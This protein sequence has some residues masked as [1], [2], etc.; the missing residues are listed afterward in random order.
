MT[1]TILK[2]NGKNQFL[3]KRLQI[4]GVLTQSETLG[5]KVNSPASSLN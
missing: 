3:M 1:K 4:E 2:R 5:A